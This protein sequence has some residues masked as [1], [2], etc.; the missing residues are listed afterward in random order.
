MKHRRTIITA[1]LAALIGLP[2]WVRTSP[3]DADPPAEPIL[4]LVAGKVYVGDGRVFAPGVVLMQ[5]GDVA[6]VYPGTEVPEEA[7]AID[8]SDGVVMPGL[9]DA[10]STLA[11]GGRDDERTVNP[12][13]RAID[14]LELREPYRRGIEGGVTTVYV[15]PGANR[16]VAGQGAIVKTAGE[17]VVEASYGLKVTLGEGP[18]FPPA[19]FE[20]PIPPSS[21]NPILPAT[22]QFPSTRMGEFALLR[23]WLSR[24]KEPPTAEWKSEAEF[25]A[26]LREVSR[27]ERPVFIEAGKADDIVKAVLLAEEWKLRIVIVGGQEADRVADLLAARKIPVVLDVGVETMGG[28]AANRAQAETQGR[29]SARAAARLSRAGVPLALR[30]PR[31]AEMRHLLL[32]A[33][34]AVRGGMEP[35]AAIRAL[36][37]GAAEILGLEKRLGVLQAGRDADVIV[38]SGEPFH[39]STL[40]ERVFVDGESVYEAPAHDAERLVA[41]FSATT[42]PKSVVAIRGGRVLQEGAR[43]LEGGLVMIED[44]KVSYVGREIE[45]PAGATIVDATGRTVAPGMINMASWDGLGSVRSEYLLRQGQSDQP[46]PKLDFAA[47]ALLAESDPAYA[48]ALASGVT[49]VLISPA[50]EGVCSLVKFTGGRPRV[51]REWAAIRFRVGAGTKAHEQM[52]KRLEQAKKYQEDWD[53][54]EKALKEGKTAEKPKSEGTEAPAED[55]ISGKWEGTGK[56]PQFGV[57]APFTLT[58]KLEG[59]KVTGTASSPQAPRSVEFEANW[60]GKK[61]TADFDQE[62]VKGSVELELVEADRLKGTFEATTPVGKVTGEAE[63]RR[64]S[65]DATAAAAAPKEPTKDDKMEPYRPLMRREIPAIVE[66]D[67]LPAIENA[68]KLFREEFDLQFVLVDAVNAY[69]APQRVVAAVDGLVYGP[70]FLGGRERR[71]FNHA[72]FFQRR[73]MPVAFYAQGVDGSA[74]LPLLAGA[75][76]HYGC[77]PDET[78]RGLTSHAARMLN[79]ERQIGAL[80]FGLDG[81]VVI[82]SGDPFDWTSRVETVLVDGAVVFERR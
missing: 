39:P 64:T 6:A 33:A 40:V 47:G 29:T 70:S 79:A 58:L 66:A 74:H 62:G 15:T 80:S 78:F 53:A 75:A 16:L 5:G 23:E 30:S 63:C 65:K 31:D 34:W 51:V 72:D 27:A 28:Y 19:L 36:T 52:K 32:A 25:M 42:Q 11:D 77:D 12:A 56:V 24:A 57:E 48:E 21:D 22:A 59:S 71:P 13:I 41:R 10:Y 3:Q 4:A 67:S 18:K 69:G 14:G 49:A 44:G 8:V 46:A 76:V 26:P 1:T 68:I 50:G 54:W 73:R 9:I 7:T 17:R 38:L 35:E 2:F 45:I 20:P 37:S 82:Y 55:P 43:P 60:D 61:L 81:D